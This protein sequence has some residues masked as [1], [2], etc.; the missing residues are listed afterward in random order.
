[1]QIVGR[2]TSQHKLFW[3]WMILSF[4]WA[5]AIAWQLPPPGSR[6]WNDPPVMTAEQSCAKAPVGERD[7][8]LLIAKIVGALRLKDPAHYTSTQKLELMLGPPIGLLVLGF[9]LVMIARGARRR[10][11]SRSQFPDN[12]GPR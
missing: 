6:E 3:F 1:M 7:T 10:A 11:T 5:S 2:I 4:L 12:P 9:V 8:C